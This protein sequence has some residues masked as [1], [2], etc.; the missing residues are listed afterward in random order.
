MSDNPIFSSKFYNSLAKLDNPILGFFGGTF[1]PP[2]LGHLIL[3]D[4]VRELFHLDFVLFVVASD[5]WQKTSTKKISEFDDRLNLV[6]L[7][8]AKNDA[9]IVSDIEKQ[10]SGQSSTLATLTKLNEK[11]PKATIRPIVGADTANGFDS[12][13]EA[14][15]LKKI[16]NFI[17][18]SRAGVQ[19]EIP[20]GWKYDFVEIPNIEISSSDIR[21]RIVE[22]KS[23]KYLV[24]ASVFEYLT[25]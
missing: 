5:P 16:A 2:H 24:P 6:E 13:H 3:A 11:F 22:G 25:D 14:E 9:F 7:A 8:T 4:Y 18:T 1:D 20:S 23:I 19:P 15:E 10:L 21:E 17:V 12:W